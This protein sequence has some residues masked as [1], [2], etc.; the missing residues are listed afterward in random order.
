MS[1]RLTWRAASRWTM[2]LSI[3]LATAD[4]FADPDLW[5]HILTGQTIL[6]TGHIPRFDTY[7]YS[8]AGMPWRNHEWLAQVALAFSYAH[9]GVFGLKLLKL[10][11]A[12]ITILA[13]AIGISATGASSRIQRMS[14]IL[15]AVALATQMQFRPQLFSFMM[16]SV[17]MT[18][19]AIEVYRGGAMLWPLIPMFALWANL[20]G[21]YTIGLGAMIIAVAVLFIQG[22]GDADR[23]TSARRLGLVTLGCAGATILNP[24]AVGLWT[25]VAH[26]ISDPLIRQVVNDW[27]PLPDTL[28]FMWRESKPELLQYAAPILLFAG[29]IAAVAVAP[30]LGDA[31]LIAVATTFIGAA[32]YAARN[33]ALAVIALAIPLARHGALALEPAPAIKL[34]YVDPPPT[35]FSNE[36]AP[37]LLAISALLLALVGGTFSNRLKTWKPVPAGAVA[38]MERN[39]L[40]GNILNQYEWG[41][42]LA[43]HM[44]NDSRVFIDGRCELVYPDRL[45]RQYAI[46][47]Y[48]MEGADGVLDAFPHDFVLIGP[49]TNGYQVVSKDR[50][51]HLLYRDETA[52]LFARA[53]LPIEAPIGGKVASTYFP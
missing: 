32:F 49:H 24:F 9:L 53:A 14:L 41:A 40:H 22:L 35:T 28:L 42:Y 30:E 34:G 47:F 48:A 44:G 29:F 2:V 23:K 21:G 11:C 50:R 10:L 5:I 8:A 43:W 37:A 27:V 38:F 3:A 15:V 1:A 36:P 17:V 33:V 4:N 25:G 51:W 20:H 12:S 39:R 31:A 6:S 18:I 45:I 46:F 19:V 13:L 7:S 26:S 16:L 52:A